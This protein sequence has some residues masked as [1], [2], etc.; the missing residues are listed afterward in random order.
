MRDD[1]SIFIVILVTIYS[2]ECVSNDL[3]MCKLRQEVQL[4]NKIKVCG[5][6]MKNPQWLKGH[7]TYYTPYEEKPNT[8]PTRFEV[9][10]PDNF[11]WDSTMSVSRGE[12]IFSNKDM[13]HISCVPTGYR[14]AKAFVFV[15]SFRYDYFQAISTFGG[16][17]L[18]VVWQRGAVVL[19]MFFSD[20]ELLDT[21]DWIMRGAELVLA[22]MY[23]L[24][25][26]F[27]I[28]GLHLNI[29]QLMSRSNS[30]RGE[31]VLSAQVHSRT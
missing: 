2:V 17:L 29:L 23:A 20:M 25:G 27:F 1:G 10:M 13:H 15:M 16:K 6:W 24:S 31:V 12:A 30:S 11:C 8:V 3:Y 19:G 28:G 9:G 5:E 14:S 7:R 4:V 21:W 26:I 18:L 22:H